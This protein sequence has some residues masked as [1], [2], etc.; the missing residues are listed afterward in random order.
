MS[1]DLGLYS[2]PW[3]QT[4]WKAYNMSKKTDLTSRNGLQWNAS[5]ISYVT[6]SNWLT[7]ESVERKPDW[8]ESYITY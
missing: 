3:C 6:A 2:K 4:L 5:N 8:L 7:H 1:T